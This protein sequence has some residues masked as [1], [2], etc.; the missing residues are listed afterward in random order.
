MDG[1]TFVTFQIGETEFM[2]LRV[3]QFFFIMQCNTIGVIRWIDLYTLHFK[4]RRDFVT[5]LCNLPSRC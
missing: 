5:M 4:A 3:S 2:L 1:F